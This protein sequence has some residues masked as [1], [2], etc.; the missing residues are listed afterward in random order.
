MFLKLVENPQHSV[1]THFLGFCEA[2]HRCVPG[3]QYRSLRLGERER[4]AI[5]YRDAA[6]QRPEPL[7]FC[8]L[9][10]RQGTNF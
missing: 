5:V 9:L 3:E 10:A 7:R 1:A 2:A 6:F 8:H 4:V